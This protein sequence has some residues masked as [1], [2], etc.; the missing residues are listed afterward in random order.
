MLRRTGGLTL[1]CLVNH[2]PP[3]YAG[4]MAALVRVLTGCYQVLSLVAA[5]ASSGR[6]H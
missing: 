5:W 2:A 6:K 3:Q 4:T 1:D